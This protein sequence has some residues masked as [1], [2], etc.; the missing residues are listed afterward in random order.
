MDH[1]Q[2]GEKTSLIQC[3]SNVD[4]ERLLRISYAEK[5]T[6]GDVLE[7]LIPTK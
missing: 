6:N 1:E 3:S 4:P 2:A 5:V 7:K